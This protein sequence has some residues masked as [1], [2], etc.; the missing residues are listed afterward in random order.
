MSDNLNLK[1]YQE[2]NVYWKKMDLLYENISK[3]PVAYCIKNNIIMSL[4]WNGETY[5][6]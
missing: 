1:I 2:K 3:L 6:F 5:C 4:P